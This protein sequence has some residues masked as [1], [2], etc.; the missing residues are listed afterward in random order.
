M[1]YDF[2]LTGNA[3]E[4]HLIPVA[5]SQEPVWGGPEKM[6]A[7]VPDYGSYR[8]RVTEESSGKLLFQKGF[9]TLFQEWQ[10]TPEA[11]KTVKS[12]YQA[13]FFPFP[14]IKVRLTIEFRDREGR[15]QPLSESAIDPADY[16]I[17]R[18]TPDQ[19]E[20][21]QIVQNGKPEDHIDLVFLS[22]GYDTGE[23]EKFREDVS[24]L[25]D[26]LFSV[27]PFSEFRQRFNVT[28]VWAPSIEAGTDIPGEHIY[29]NTSLNSTFY[30][31][32]L[33]RYLS[34]SDMKSVYDMA[35]GV[36]WDHLFVLVNTPRYGGGGFYNLVCV[37]SSG[38][39]L[40]PKVL[41]HEFGHAFAGLADEYYTSSVAYEDFYNL[42][43]EPWEPNITTLVDFNSKW[44]SMLADSIPVP[45]PRNE[46]FIHQLGVFEGG[47][48][49][50]K[51]IYSPMQDCRMK[52]NTT[53]DFCKVCENAIRKMI[54]QQS[55]PE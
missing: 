21:M 53:D 42:K 22:E 40:S 1:R 8:Y 3:G 50:S 10:T 38:H 33:D 20:Y 2:L 18:E 28:G 14:K 45:T 48:Y 55:D 25:C 27:R 6:M 37:C 26:Y 4:V 43:T 32:D 49:M 9:C 24:S 29:R 47:G 23:R 30:T 11:K 12:F 36:A 46:R 31:F 16:F 51:G 54:E 34:T 41:V 44:K 17:N 15:F 7:A 39:P 13:V 52:S 5:I 19:Y 35:A